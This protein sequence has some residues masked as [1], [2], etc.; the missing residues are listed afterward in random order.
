MHPTT[1]EF[2]MELLNS[3]KR[4]S[5]NVHCTT[6]E[7]ACGASKC[8]EFSED[9]LALLRAAGFNGT[10]TEAKVFSHVFIHGQKYEMEPK[11]A[12]NK[13]NNSFC[14]V[15]GAGIFCIRHI[16]VMNN[17]CF[18]KC[19]KVSYKQSARCYPNLYF[20]TGLSKRYY[21]LPAFTV[22]KQ[23]FLILRKEDFSTKFIFE[24]PNCAEVE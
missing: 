22:T 15:E 1:R 21:W 10:C 17:L 16:V 9:D 6:K 11:E 5:V 24:V 2:L 20:Y 23:R 19:Q 18:L 12:S 3:R 4:Y 8:Y 7:T 14:Q 13:F